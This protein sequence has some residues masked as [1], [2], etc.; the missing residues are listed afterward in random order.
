VSW[1]QMGWVWAQFGHSRTDR[2]DNY[3]KLSSHPFSNVGPSPLVAP[4]HAD[5]TLHREQVV[6]K[7][8][9]ACTRG[10]GVLRP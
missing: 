6:R 9:V 4:A 3:A 8:A 2:W 5:P 7:L 1:A 10:R